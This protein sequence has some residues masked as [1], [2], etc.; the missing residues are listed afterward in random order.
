LAVSP[1]SPAEKAGIKT[2]DAIKQAKF[3]NL[4]V[5]INKVKELQDFVGQHKGQEITITIQRGKDVLDVSLIPRVTISSTEGPMGIELVRTA[6]KSYPWYLAPYEGVKT[7]VR[8]TILS[9]EGW[10]QAITNIVN[11]KPSGVQLMGPV[12]IF[13]LFTQVSQLGVIYFLQFVAVISIFMAL[14]N[15]LPI[16]AV[17]GGKLLFLIIEKI[18]GKPM[19]K[20]IE[21]KVEGFF[22]S[23]LIL[24]AV[25][26]TI[27][28]IIRLF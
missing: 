17:D 21:Q 13:S 10:G 24:L 22:F 25:W 1:D 8:L 23:L 5:D 12:G 3:Q 18:R 27:K 7:T 11:K 19:K 20:E 4:A 16:P 9:L 15:I 2:G 6:L 26:V 14:F 28:D